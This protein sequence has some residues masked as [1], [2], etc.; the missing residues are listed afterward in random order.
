MR[1]G[2]TGLTGGIGSGKSTVSAQLRTMGYDIVD[3]DL[4]TRE[5]HRDEAVC[6]ALASAFGDAVIERIDGKVCVARKALGARVFGDDDAMRA[7]NGIMRPALRQ[8]A[9]AA[10]ESSR[11]PVILDA[12]LLYE[13][14]WDE[15]V[16]DVVVVVSH[17][18]ER[19]RRVAARDGLNLAE[20]RRRI[21]HQMTDAERVRRADILIYNVGSFEALS[22]QVRRI[23]G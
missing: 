17:E 11:K 1:C 10:I 5:V 19:A 3:A 6:A 15:W 22:A 16:D 18:G 23:F 8:A 4:L 2:I 20:V 12:A 7:L 14:S 13:A 21:A 9:Q